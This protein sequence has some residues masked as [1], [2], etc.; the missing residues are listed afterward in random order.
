M[1]LLIALIFFCSSVFGQFLNPD[2]LDVHIKE[3]MEKLD[4]PGLSIAIVNDDSLEYI[5][6]YGKKNIN[7]KDLV[8][9]NTLFGIGSISKSFTALAI[10]LLVNDG[11]MDWDDRVI[12]YLPYFELYDRYVTNNFTIRDLLTHRSGLKDISGGTLSFG[13]SLL[14]R[15]EIIKRLKYLK[16]ASGFRYTPAYQNIMY[17][18]AGEVVSKVSGMSW[19]EF[20]KT[21]IFKPLGMDNSVACYEERQKSKNIA[22]PHIQNEKFEN[23]LITQEISDNAAPAGFIFSSANDMAKYIKFFLN[24]GIVGQDTLIKKEVIDEIFTPQIHYPIWKNHNEFTSYGFGW[25]LT[26]RNGHKVIEHSG[27]IDG[28]SSNLMMVSD[29]DYGVVIMGNPS[30][31]LRFILC[32]EIIGNKLDDNILLESSHNY[33]DYRLNKRKDLMLEARKMVLDSRIKN[34][35]PSLKKKEYAT[36]FTDEMYGDVYVTYDNK[37]LLIEFE[38]TPLFTGE[39]TH[40]HYDTFK[41]DWV[42]PRVTDGYCTFILDSK[43]KISELKLD[44]PN[45]LDVDFTE[46]TLLVKN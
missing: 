32:G 11:K 9:E 19:E 21:R 8:D 37:K 12:D 2:T 28:M 14:S 17:I 24:D 4:V 31:G 13:S 3:L 39:L 40:W 25:W 18:V 33:L 23:I 43:G 34:T 16:P 35:K 26:P 45:L 22:L 10:G 41:I 36:T 29:L 27:G 38:H 44:Q 15:P 1:K 20:I 30:Y 46:L 42:D 7:K 6:G 5:K